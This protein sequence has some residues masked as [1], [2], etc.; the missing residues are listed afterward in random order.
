MLVESASTDQPVIA[1]K[2]STKAQ[3]PAGWEN[4]WEGSNQCAVSPVALARHIMDAWLYNP[5]HRQNILNPDYTHM[6]I[7]IASNDGQIRATQ[8]FATLQ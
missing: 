5:G 4:I 2:S 8:L 3:S 1:S 6:G 7:G